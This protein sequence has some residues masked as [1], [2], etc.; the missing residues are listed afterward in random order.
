MAPNRNT[1]RQVLRHGRYSTYDAGG[2][3]SQAQRQTPGAGRCDPHEPDGILQQSTTDYGGLANQRSALAGAIAT[4]EH[5]FCDQKPPYHQARQQGAGKSRTR[6]LVQ[7]VEAD[8]IGVQGRW[9]HAPVRPTGMTSARNTAAS[10]KGVA[11]ATG[12]TLIRAW[13]SASRP[14]DEGVDGQD[15]SGIQAEADC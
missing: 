5:R 14:A 7:Q 4:G 2:G 8:A 12:P 9:R 15:G 10:M 1:G 3:P 11:E 6:A 13:P